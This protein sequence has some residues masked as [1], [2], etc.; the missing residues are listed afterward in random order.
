MN[1]IVSGRVITAGEHDYAFRAPRFQQVL[2]ES[3][4]VALLAD[5]DPLILI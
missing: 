5:F 4:H 3:K 2:E 1:E